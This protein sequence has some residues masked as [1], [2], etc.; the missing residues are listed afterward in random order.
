MASGNSSEIHS[1]TLYRYIYLRCSHHKK[2]ILYDTTR[3]DTTGR[4][5][6][7]Y[8]KIEKEKSAVHFR[9]G[10]GIVVAICY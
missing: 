4:K 2:G 9:A 6:E 3:N 5:A 1:G 10:Q 7:E 8:S